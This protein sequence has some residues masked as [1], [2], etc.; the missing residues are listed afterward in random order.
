MSDEENQ[1]NTRDITRI[2]PASDRGRIIKIALSVLAGCVVIGML[3]NTGHRKKEP[4]AAETGAATEVRMPDFGDYKSRAHKEGV[5][6]P[7]QDT[8][9]SPD[10]TSYGQ[11]Q[12]A[13][14]AAAPPARQTNT[15]TG[16]QKSGSGDEAANN[17]KLAQIS[18][19]VP[20]VQGSLFAGSGYAPQAPQYSQSPQYAQNAYG[21]PVSAA[22]TPAGMT[23]SQDY[24]NQR[25]QGL[26]AL[27][28]GGGAAGGNSN[29]QN[30]NMQS[31]KQ[32]FYKQTDTGTAK[33][34]YI[35]ANTLWN[36]SVIPAVLITGIN[37]DLPGDVQ[38]RV[39]Q[40]IYDSLSGKSLLIPQGTILIAAYNS[41]VSFAQSRVQIAW[42]TLIRP[43][44]FQLDLGT[45]NGV[46]AQ[47]FSGVKGHYSENLFQYLKAA[48]IISVFTVLNGQIT[49][50][51]AA[52]NNAALQNLM[53]ANQQVMN[54]LSARII[55]RALDIQ[56]T[57]KVKNG[58][59]INIML[60][61]NIML[62][63]LEDYPVSAKYV[64][65]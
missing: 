22:Y 46:D 41:N 32:A 39:T 65:K 21:Q 15:G 27:S 45:M 6:V 11:P 52:T 2:A 5:P 29:Y 25:L 31:D 20:E 43:D 56:P 7:P 24:L 14:P 58:T 3:V 36:G 51:T 17:L 57:I 59:Q 53:L 55:D 26:S 47:G 19:L 44:G 23:S 62:P 1:E 28:A 37:T 12:A 42:N 34:S 38:A 30:Q 4:K 61:K 64:R 9:D 13:R 33:G 63:P 60:N 50:S 48:G 8:P 49:S 16:V 35:G 40:N 10:T 18:P 54:Q